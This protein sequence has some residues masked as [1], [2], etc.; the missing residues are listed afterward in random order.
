M[1]MSTANDE[2]EVIDEETTNTAPEEQ[3]K[4]QSEA[5]RLFQV[6]I[7]TYF[8]LFFSTLPVFNDM[9]L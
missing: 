1:V 3:G 7:K 8:L 2:P 5:Q 9:K 6:S 4:K